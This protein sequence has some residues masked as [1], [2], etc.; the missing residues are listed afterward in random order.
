MNNIPI[1]SSASWYL[2]EFAFQWNRKDRED[3]YVQK[4]FQVGCY[5]HLIFLLYHP[6]FFWILEYCVFVCYLAHNED[7][8]LLILPTHPNKIKICI[9]INRQNLNLV[10]FFKFQHL[11]YNGFY[12]QDFDPHGRTLYNSQFVYSKP[13]LK[14]KNCCIY[15]YV[16][17]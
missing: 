17:Y 16:Y 15:V 4:I 5:I 1:R 2:K 12:F 11:M 3:P 9:R 13:F 14:G 8:G 6:S 10:N 7:Q